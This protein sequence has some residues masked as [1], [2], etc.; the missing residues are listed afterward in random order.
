MRWQEF[1]ERLSE[2]VGLH[3]VDTED[4]HVQEDRL[5]IDVLNAIADGSCEFPCETARLMAAQMSAPL[6]RWYA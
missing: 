5:A 3:A 1:S 6:R 2:V 4:F